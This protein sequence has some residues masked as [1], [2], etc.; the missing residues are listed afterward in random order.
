MYPFHRYGRRG[1]WSWSHAQEL[2]QNR[3]GQCISLGRF[4]RFHTNQM[5]VL[6]SCNPCKQLQ[7]LVAVKF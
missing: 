6:L 7:V 3:M 4:R 1:A 2:R 5:Y